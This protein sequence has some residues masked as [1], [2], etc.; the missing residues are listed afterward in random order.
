[1]EVDI[2]LIVP[3]DAG[4]AQVMIELIEMLFDEWY[5]ARERRNRRLAN[6]AEIR[7]AKDE[8]KRGAKEAKAAT[9]SAAS[10]LPNGAAALEE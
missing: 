10:I 1:M 4:E 2:D 8:I 6:I 9:S 3:V 5:G 7:S